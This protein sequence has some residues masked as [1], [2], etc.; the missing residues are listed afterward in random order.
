MSN[1]TDATPSL[2]E[3]A[4][5][6]GDWTALRLH[7]ARCEKLDKDYRTPEE[8]AL[9]GELFKPYE[10][11]TKLGWQD[12]IYCPKDGTEFLSISAGSTGVHRC[13]YDGE[14]PKGCWWVLEAGDMWPARPILWKPM[15]PNAPTQPRREEGGR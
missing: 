12:I 13:H 3:S 6:E 11:L 15:P 2:P 4:G 1:K 9:L 10:A 14:W 5:S 7:W 8:R